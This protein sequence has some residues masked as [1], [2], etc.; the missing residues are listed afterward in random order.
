MEAELA[1]F[2]IMIVSCGVAGYVGVRVAQTEIK[3]DIEYLRRDIGRIWKRV[4]DE[5]YG[6]VNDDE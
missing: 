4:F 2:A 5:P 3:K 6:R 1:R